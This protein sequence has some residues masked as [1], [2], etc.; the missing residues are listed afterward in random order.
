[1]TDARPFR[2]H[3]G[4]PETNR[5]VWDNFKAHLAEERE[6]LFADGKDLEIVVQPWQTKRSLAQ[7]RLA[8]LYFREIS[9]CAR[10]TYGYN[11]TPRSVKEE[12]KE[13]FLGE[14][15]YESITGEVKTYTRHTS[16][17][18]VSAMAYFLEQV[19]AWAAERGCELTKPADLWAQAMGRE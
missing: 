13:M 17:L 15:S 18:S 12:L 7:N 2:F 16:D 14:E 6:R 8:H 5:A 10:E 1:M 3:A 11:C 19:E 9:D 4:Q